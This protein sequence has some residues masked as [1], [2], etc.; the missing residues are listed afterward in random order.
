MN[1]WGFDFGYELLDDGWKLAYPPPDPR[2]AEVMRQV[3]AA[4]RVNQA[5]LAAAAPRE[6]GSRSKTVYHASPHGGFVREGGSSDDDDDDPGYRSARPA[7]AVGQNRGQGTGG[8]GQGTDGGQGGA[9]AVA[10]NPY[11]VSP[12]SGGQ[13]TGG[14]GGAPGVAGS[15]TGTAG[16]NVFGGGGGTG[17]AGDNIG[18]V[19]GGGG[20]SGAAAGGTGSGGGAAGSGN[21]GPALTGNGLAG[22][23]NAQ[24]TTGGSASP[25]GIAS[26]GGSQFAGS[27]ATGNATQSSTGAG[28]GSSGN[29]SGG[30]AVSS[31]GQSGT[32]A[33]GGRAERPDGYVVGQPAHEQPTP[34]ASSETPSADQHGRILRPGEWEPSPD[35]P[36][37]KHDDKDD[38][39]DDSPSGKHAK[40]LASKR[41]A[42]WGLRDAGRGAVGVTRPIRIECYGDHLVVV[43]D[44]NPDANKVIAFRSRTA[45]AVDPLVSAIWEQ[46][47]TWGMAGRG[48][49]WRPLLQ[50]Y[51]APDAG[52]RFTELSRLLDGS[53][54]LVERK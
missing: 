22:G 36:P 14:N 33:A 44:R 50:V 23:T 17:G 7:G 11:V 39:D 54:L 52:Q 48:M 31:N 40:S 35:P 29:P 16:G 46:M 27:G 28:T 2:L 45:S 41:G 4:A 47:E 6:Y 37:K 43:S 3:V 8:G 49:F 38:K 42:D 12:G 53:G 15:G 5:R 21:A 24:N 20:R 51:V 30:S 18:S 9:G 10:A 1:S 32:A 26:P 13:A 34:T 25:G 19:F